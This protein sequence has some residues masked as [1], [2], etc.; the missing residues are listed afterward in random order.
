MSIFVYMNLWQRVC[1][2]KK[3]AIYDIFF[4]LCV[5]ILTCPHLCVQPGHGV[6]S[7]PASSRL[8]AL[9]RGHRGSSALEGRRPVLV[10]LFL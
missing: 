9:F 8:V 10:R 1:Q 3:F 5:I 4:S 6:V 2:P 7:V